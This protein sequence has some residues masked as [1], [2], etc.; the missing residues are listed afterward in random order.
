M[1][2]K[3]VFENPL[4]NCTFSS[5]FI[6]DDSENTELCKTHMIVVLGSALVLILDVLL[7]YYVISKIRS[8]QAY[9]VELNYQIQV[10]ELKLLE[11]AL[12]AQED[13]MCDF[14][15]NFLKNKI[16]ICIDH[17]TSET[18]SISKV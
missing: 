10:L 13:S 1:S 18:S 7:V 3:T 16:N 8:N 14:S 12:E 5:I 4:D 6:N 15:D 2:N 11:F 17:E 9:E